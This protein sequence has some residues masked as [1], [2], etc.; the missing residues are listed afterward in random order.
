MVHTWLANSAIHF[1][2]LSNL[3]L[4]EGT[5]G[6]RGYRYA[7]MTAG[8]IGERIYVTSTSLGL[9]CCGIGAFYDNEASD[10]I[11]L[12]ADSR[13]LYLVSVGKVKRL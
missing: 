5:W 9:G 10:L 11:G 8:R 7:M 4:L 6:Q 1:L 12:N 2:F 3:A 13:L